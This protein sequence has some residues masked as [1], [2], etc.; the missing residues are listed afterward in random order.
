MVVFGFLVWLLGDGWGLIAFAAANLIIGFFCAVLAARIGL[1]MRPNRGVG[2]ATRRFRVNTFTAL[3]VTLPV[4][5]LIAHGYV[6]AWITL[7]LFVAGAAAALTFTR[8]LT[9]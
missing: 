8:R 2:Q 6:N 5:G 9:D 3:I 1:Y 7:G 4:R